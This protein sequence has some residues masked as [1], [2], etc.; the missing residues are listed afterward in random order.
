MC[1][2]RHGLRLAMWIYGSRLR[3]FGYKVGNSIWGLRA[4]ASRSGA[5]GEGGGVET[6]LFSGEEGMA[7]SLLGVLFCTVLR[8]YFK[9]I[10]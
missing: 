6:R 4:S 8:N 7:D 10:L 5:C 9:I 2:A 1:Q 3:G